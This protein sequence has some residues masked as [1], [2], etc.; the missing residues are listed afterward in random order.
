MP[1]LS[2]QPS[3][4]AY[5]RDGGSASANFGTATNLAV[6]YD[7]TV[8]DGYNRYTFLKFDVHAL[9]NLLSARLM[10]T[11]I[12]VDGIGNLAFERWSND[13]WGE[14]TITWNNQPAGSGTTI[15]NVANYTLFTP[16]IVD[17]TTVAAGEATNDGLLT[18]RVTQPGANATR[19]D[20]CSREHP[21]N[22]WRPVLQ[23]SVNDNT[24]P[25]LTVSGN[26]TTDVGVT[27]NLTN[28]ATDSDAPAQTLTFS[29]LAAPA[30]AV[31]NSRSGV[32]TWRPIVTQVNSTNRFS[33]RVADSGTPSM[34]ATQSFFVAV[35]PLTPPRFSAVSAVGGVLVL[36]V[37]GDSG[38]DYQVQSSTNLLNWNVVLTTNSPAIPFVWTASC[39]N[40]PLNF[41]RVLTGP[42]F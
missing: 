23:Y 26:Q 10:L 2:L 35:A 25:V 17:L 31:I 5:V 12:Q 13:T 15:T 14:N 21:T 27:L 8:G 39:T 16:A 3:A 18:I 28:S 37:S 36:Q 24:A 38:P 6:K 42:P 20:F 11:P 40:G 22:S 30:N 19:I 41:F 7:G 34:S 29:L 9:T 33:V 4:D 32:V 1:V